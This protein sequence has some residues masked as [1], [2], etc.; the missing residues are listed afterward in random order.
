MTGQDIG[1]G[2]VAHTATRSDNRLADASLAETAEL[3]I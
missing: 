2:L 3:V 1:R